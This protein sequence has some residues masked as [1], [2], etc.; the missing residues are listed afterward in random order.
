MS[1]VSQLGMDGV[2]VG[3]GIFKSGDPL[4]RAQVNA[5]S[6]YTYLLVALE[7]LSFNENELKFRSSVICFHVLF[8]CSHAGLTPPQYFF[9]AIVQAVTHFKDP[10]KLAEVSSGLGE[11]MVRYMHA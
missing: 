7:S 11:A 9:Q 2:F 8:D 6:F 3:S 4:K 5:F 10:V 1:C